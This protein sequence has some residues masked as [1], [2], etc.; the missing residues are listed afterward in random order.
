MNFGRILEVIFLCTNILNA[1]LD[2][3]NKWRSSSQ[4][5][6]HKEDI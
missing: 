1:L 2:L 4:D 5:D 3:I 6:H